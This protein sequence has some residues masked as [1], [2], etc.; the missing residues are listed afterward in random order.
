MSDKTDTT[1][2][3]REVFPTIPA[4][5]ISVEECMGRLGIS[6][7]TMYKLLNSGRIRSFHIYGRRLI[8]E[9]ALREFIHRSEIEGQA[10]TT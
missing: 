1:S 8:S 2:D 3:V 5:A 6:R 9:E 4:S 7:G 10:R